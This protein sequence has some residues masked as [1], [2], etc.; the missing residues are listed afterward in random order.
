[1]PTLKSILNPKTY[2]RF[3]WRKIKEQECR[4]RPNLRGAV[5]FPP[6]H[7][8]SPLLD[9]ES[10]GLG[11][12]RLPFDGAE[13]WEH[14]RLHEHSQQSYYQEL[15]ESFPALAW[16]REHKDG[17][18]Y[19]THNGYF[20]LSDAFALAGIIRKERPRQIIEVGSGFSSAVMLDALD[21][22]GIHAALTFIEPFP[23]ERLNALLSP[24]D[25]STT[26]IL[27]HKVQ[28]TPVSEFDAL[29][30]QDILF[31]DSSHVAK[32]GSDVAFLLLRVLPRLKQGVF[33]HFHDIF[34]PFSYPADWIR[35]GLAW[36]ESLFLRAFLLENTN[37]E[38]VMFNSYAGFSFPKLFNTKF[39]A[40]L[41]DTGGSIWLKK[42]G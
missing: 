29:E 13:Y 41:D 16:T 1:M 17:L 23:D 4:L 5:I 42:V 10:L 36:N 2:F 15:I 19:R 21:S 30:A 31:I 6:G 22:A 40:F 35:R 20:G 33:V 26:R 28:E 25:K 14:I 38:V 27:A 32:I 37:F 3:A 34:Y 8:Y 11:D 24:K 9:I 12:Q 18:R 39:P 7:F